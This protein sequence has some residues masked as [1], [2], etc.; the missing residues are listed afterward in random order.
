ME[1]L[2][3]VHYL[4]MNDANAKSMSDAFTRRPNLTPYSA[5]IPG[6]LCQPPVDPTLVPGCTSPGNHVITAAVKPLRG[7]KWWAKAT[8]QFNFKRPDLNNA[9]AFNRVL[10]KGLWAT[11]SPIPGPEASTR[12]LRRRRNPPN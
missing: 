2:L 3:G 5:I 12:S 6:I 4:G 10:W 11:T 1:D 9:D 8:A 7:G